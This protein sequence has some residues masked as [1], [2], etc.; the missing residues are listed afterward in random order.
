MASTLIR[1]LR[2]TVEQ[3]KLAIETSGVAGVAVLQD[4]QRLI[5]SGRQLEDGRTLGFYN[6]QHQSHLHLVKRL[7]GC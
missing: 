7:V 3:V 1:I 6:I 4:Q 5:Y 2:K